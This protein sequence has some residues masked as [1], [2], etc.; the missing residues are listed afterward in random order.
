MSDHSTVESDPAFQVSKWI[1]DFQ[2]GVKFKWDPLQRV[3]LHF[4]GT[5]CQGVQMQ[6]LVQNLFN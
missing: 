5:V 1:G 4:G 6:F 3:G 2:Y